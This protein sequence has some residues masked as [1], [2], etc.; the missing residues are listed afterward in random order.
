M[1]SSSSEHSSFFICVNTNFTMTICPIGQLDNWISGQL[2]IVR[3]CVRACVRSNYNIVG[4]E[5]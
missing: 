2:H 1:Y 4:S 5:L 3:A